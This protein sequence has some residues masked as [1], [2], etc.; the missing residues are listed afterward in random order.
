[1]TE[2]PQRVQLRKQRV[3]DVLAARLL[4]RNRTEQSGQI[5]RFAHVSHRGDRR[6]AG[7]QPPEGTEPPETLF[8]LE[9]A[10]T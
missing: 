3:L 1:M 6:A 4:L 7:R 9:T 8:K 10:M 5:Q 2:Y